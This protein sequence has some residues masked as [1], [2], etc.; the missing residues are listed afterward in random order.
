MSIFFAVIVER[1]AEMPDSDYSKKSP[2]MN[3][4]NSDEMMKQV[5][6]LSSGLVIISKKNHS[7]GQPV[8]HE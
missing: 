6:S 1:W 2:K 4:L 7:V 3:G 5:K 8:Q